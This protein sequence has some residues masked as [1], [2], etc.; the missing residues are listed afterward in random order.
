M[1]KWLTV[2]MR[3]HSAIYLL[4]WLGLL[5]KIC[6]RSSSMA[7][8]CN[9]SLPTYLHSLSLASN[10]ND[11]KVDCKSGLSGFGGSWESAI[12]PNYS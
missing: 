10:I 7:P 8:S 3:P 11:D 1:H 5:S 6:K 2:W 9:I 12:L 4:S